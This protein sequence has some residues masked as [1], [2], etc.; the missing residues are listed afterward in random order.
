MLL[1]CI[2][3]FTKRV[4]FKLEVQD[5][6]I[7]GI[8]IVSRVSKLTFAQPVVNLSLSEPV[9]G[10]G[11]GAPR[12]IDFPLSSERKQPWGGG[13]LTRIP[14]CKLVT[15]SSCDQEGLG[16]RRYLQVIISDFIQRYFMYMD[17]KSTEDR[18]LLFVFLV[19]MTYKSLWL[20][21]MST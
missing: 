8:G 1:R 19:W 15:G 18:F 2:I 14:R 21:S 10:H 3:S 6:S 12:I 7:P 5:F 20:I 11:H 9:E 16:I 13:A 17:F 4:T